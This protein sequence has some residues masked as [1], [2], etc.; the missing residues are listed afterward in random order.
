MKKI[1]YAIK[2]VDLK[3]IK[4]N[5][6]LAV[7][8]NEEDTLFLEN[9]I[10]QHGLLTNIVLFENKEGENIVVS[11]EL[12]IRALRNMRITVDFT[13]AIKAFL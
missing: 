10:R 12:E 8:S 7:N 6:I 3:Y 2:E 1:K 5:R 4:S 11:G 9:N 13:F